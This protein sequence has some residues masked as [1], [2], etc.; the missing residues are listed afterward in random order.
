MATCNGID[1]SVRYLPPNP[2]ERARWVKFKREQAE[3][4]D[5]SLE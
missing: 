3:E 2:E 5:E 1:I 4:F